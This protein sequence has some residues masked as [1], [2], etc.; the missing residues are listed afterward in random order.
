MA[1]PFDGKIG[2]WHWKGDSLGE[3][4]ID[5]LANTMKNWTP[6]A[7]A[8]FIKTNDGTA[9]QGQFD[10][11]PA[12][13]INGTNDV[14]K[15]VTTM[16]NHGIEVHAWCVV[17]G[18]DVQAEAQRII[19]VCKVPGVQSM[20]LDV[21][22]YAGYFQG[23]QN[24]VVQLMTAVRSGIGQQYH[25]G[26]A[27]DPRRAHYDR[28]FP[29]AWRLY[30]NS[31]HPYI[32]WEEMGRPP[33]D[34]MDECYAVWGN[35]GLPIIPALQGNAPPSEIRTAQDNA[36]SVRGAPG[37]SYFRLGVMGASELPI[38]NDEKVEEE[39]GP[40]GVKR[41]YGA[42]LVIRPG[43]P[44]FS[45]GTHTANAF[46]QFSG[47]G[48]Y[49]VQYK[50]TNA[51]TDE[52]WARWRPA[53]PKSGRWEVS[54][55]IPS[56][57]ATTS[58][59]K[60][61]IHGV[62]GKGPELI[63][64]FDQNRYSNQWVPMVVYN[65]EQGTGSG[66]VNLTDLTGETGKEIA[67]DAVRWREVLTEDQ[68]VTP[69]PTTPDPTGPTPTP[70]TGIGFD[71]PVGTAA[72]R[73]GT[74]VWPGFWFDATGYATFYSFVGGSAYHT[75]ADLNLNNPHWDADRDAPV[76]AP[77][78][79]SVVYSGTRQT[80]GDIIIIRHDPLPDGTVVWSRLAHVSHRLV[81]AGE[82][83][84]RGQQIAQI[85]NANGAQP[86]H[87][88]FDIAKT[89]ILESSPGHWPGTTKALVFEHYVDPKKFIAE[90]RPAG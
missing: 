63:A 3:A 61:H 45:S 90:H 88:H 51:Q 49:N 86:Y 31:L 85:G 74:K 2:L 22:P 73:A 19:S 25:L 17:K 71:S 11:K 7:D 57:H 30:V 29:D 46:R 64:S 4:T 59:A 66:Q 44:G 56:R 23:D 83:V 28:I 8:V 21:E 50:S 68:V 18:V 80:W 34:V 87:L 27:M 72:E 43:D 52:V 62:E 60:Y 70:G 14:A 54:V 75:G 12:M 65:F 53:L 37:V 26:L 58:A 89:N 5:D 40:D 77:C 81:S 76:Y 1:T 10:K 69:P 35:Y 55:Y 6:S 33:I 82:R 42:E 48:G 15:W 84:A 13:A 79:G 78:D 36:R 32:Y 38:V 24:T 20:L 9:W 39:I 16:G 47:V 41:T 67:F